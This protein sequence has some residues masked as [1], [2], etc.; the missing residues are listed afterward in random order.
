MLNAYKKKY[1]KIVFK[2]DGLHD[3]KQFQTQKEKIEKTGFCKTKSKVQ[4]SRD[5]G[6]Y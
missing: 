5:L 3:T 1:F 4:S 2:K 6:G